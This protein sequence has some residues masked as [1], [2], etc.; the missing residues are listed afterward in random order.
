MWRSKVWGGYQNSI[1]NEG[2]V[3]QHPKATERKGEQ[4]QD[5]I[6]CK[7]LERYI[8]RGRDIDGHGFLVVT[9]WGLK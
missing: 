4:G 6:G 1:E 7:R 2:W 8:G 3:L 5:G 9:N